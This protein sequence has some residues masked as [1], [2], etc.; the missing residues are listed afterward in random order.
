MASRAGSWSGS[1]TPRG[2][3]MASFSEGPD[4]S[5]KFATRFVFPRGTLAC[6]GVEDWSGSKSPRGSGVASF[7]P[8]P[9]SRGHKHSATYFYCCAYVAVTNANSK[10]L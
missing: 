10:Y 2:S 5:D 8:G 7:A 6:L 1:K 4:W 3:Q 9:D